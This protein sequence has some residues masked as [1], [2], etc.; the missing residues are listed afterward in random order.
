MRSI[1]RGH[2]RGEFLCVIGLGKTEDETRWRPGR[3]LTD[4][5]DG[6]ELQP[7]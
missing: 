6:P 3:I 2:G 1:A 4:P 7:S 5:P